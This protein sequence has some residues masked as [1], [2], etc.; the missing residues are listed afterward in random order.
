MELEASCSWPKG[1]RMQRGTIAAGNGGDMEEQDESMSLGKS[2]GKRVQGLRNKT[3][4]RR[5]RSQKRT[6][7]TG[8]TVSRRETARKSRDS[9][10]RA[11]PRRSLPR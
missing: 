3:I 1:T 5:N 11:A 8:T 6:A 7:C 10:R 4:A 2:G 9:R